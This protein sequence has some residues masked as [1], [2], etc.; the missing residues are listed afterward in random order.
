M[1]GVSTSMGVQLRAHHQLVRHGP[2]G[3]A[4][5]PMYLGYWLM[6]AGALLTYRTWA[7]LLYALSLLYSL[8]LRAR[9]EE[10]VL[11]ATF[12]PAWHA[13][14]ARVPMLGLRGHSGK[15]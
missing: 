1:W 14:A 2:Y 15:S 6:L 3:L 13:Y 9:R 5:H 4:R 12:G 11:A 8:A 7:L 10:E